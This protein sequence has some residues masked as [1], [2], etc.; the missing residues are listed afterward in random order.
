MSTRSRRSRLAH[1]GR[2]AWRAGTLGAVVRNPDAREQQ[3]RQRLPEERGDLGVEERHPGCADAERVRGQVQAALHDARV[4]LGLA[5][6]A[7][8]EQVQVN[9]ADDDERGVA[10]QV[11]PVARDPQL[12][13]QRPLRSGR[14][15]SGHR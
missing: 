12:V 6:P 8:V 9:G 1:V 4:E 5:V 13:P 15:R 10:A 2:V 14:P 7:V 11:L 3:R